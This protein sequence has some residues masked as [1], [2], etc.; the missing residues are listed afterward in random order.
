MNRKTTKWL[1]VGALLLLGVG[2][3]AGPVV[4]LDDT[5]HPVTLPDD[6]DGYL[7]AQEQRY[8]DIV[9][10]TEKT[11]AWANPKQH[12]PTPVALVF[13]HGFTA[14]RR[15]L[16]PLC[17]IIAGKLGANVFYQRFTGH[18][19]GSEAMGR[20][21]VNALVN[22]TYEALEIGKRIGQKVIVVGNSNGGTMATLMATMDTS[23]ALAALILISPNFGPKRK[24]A[25]LLLAPWGNVM[26]RLV[27]GPM[28]TYKTYNP[29]HARYWTSS[30]PSKALLPM[31][32][33]VKLAR[34]ADLQQI[35]TPVLVLYSP[36]DQ[37]VSVDAIKKHYRR[38]GADYK[39]IHAVTGSGDPQ[40]HI[41][42]GDVLSPQT[43]Q[44]VASVILKF[45]QP[46]F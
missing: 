27:Q 29:Q 28:Y 17:K 14:S 21:T 5:I 40:H 12:S 9:P 44:Q 3:V 39:Q 6:L 37:I 24:E 32:G 42:A 45:I 35:K 19:R 33:T 4:D 43:T 31:M 7:R 13:L 46:L 16:A 25:E 22:D 38:F 11:I 34:D 20:V 26:V 41:L 1:I 36:D 18:G 10:G 8:D 15:E 23:N 2:F 30:S